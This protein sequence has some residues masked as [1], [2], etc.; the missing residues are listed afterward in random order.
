MSILCQYFCNMYGHHPA[1]QAGFGWCRPPASLA[2]ASSRLDSASIAV[3]K[4]NKRRGK[5]LCLRGNETSTATSRSQND[6]AAETV[7][8][9]LCRDAARK[10]S[11]CSQ[12]AKGV[13]QYMR[14]S[15][16]NATRHS[17]CLYSPKLECARTQQSN[18]AQR[19]SKHSSN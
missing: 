19:A 7:P 8:L 12:E 18:P 5:R 1:H 16:F 2:L 10:N 4:I 3:W 11:L 17:R 6:A 9:D 15:S 13:G 14:L